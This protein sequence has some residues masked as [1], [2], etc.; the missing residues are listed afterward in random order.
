MLGPV[1]EGGCRVDVSV[2]AH[3]EHGTLVT[4]RLGCDDTARRAAFEEQVRAELDPLP[5]RHEIVWR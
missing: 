1:A 3:A 5:L 4:V 2:G